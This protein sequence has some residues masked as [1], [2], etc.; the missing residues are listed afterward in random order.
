MSQM[1][2]ASK[3]AGIVDTDASNIE[4]AYQMKT[5]LQHIMDLPDTYIGSVQSEK[6][7]RWIK[8]SDARFIHSD[9]EFPPGLMHI[10][11][12]ILVNAYD[13]RNRVMQKLASGIKGLKPVSTI[14]VNVD[15]N[16]G[17][18]AIEN[19]G[20]GI[21][22]AMHQGAQVYVPE[23]I[24]GKLLTSGNYKT[25]EKRIVGG[26]NGYGAK[27]TNI[28]SKSFRVE[29]VDRKRKLYFCQDYFNNMSERTE[30][31]IKEN[32]KGD[33]FTRITFTPDYARFG[34]GMTKS[35]MALIEKRAYDMVACSSGQVKV[36]F[37]DIEV[38]ATCF[39]DYISMYI[40]ADAERSVCKVN[41][42]WEVAV[43]L[44]NSHGFEQVSFVNG[45]NTDRGGRHVDYVVKQITEA[46][47]EQIKKKKKVDVREDVIKS[48]IFV[49]VNSIIENPAF[50]SQTKNTL[51]TPKSKF[52][53]ECEVPEKFIDTILAAGLMDRA[54]ALSE[55]RDK[56]LL[57]KTDGKKVKRVL[58][59][60][61]LDDARYA[62]TKRSSECTLILTEGDS[63]KATAV[64]GISIFP[65]GRDYYG[66]F[67]LRGKPLNTRDRAEKD[68]AANVEITNI[69]KILGLQ[70]GKEYK[71]TSELR[72]GSIMLMTDADLDG[73][74]IKGL[75]INFFSHW[76]SLMRL[77]GFIT[78]LL[79]PILKASKGKK[80]VN[81]YSKPEFEEWVEARGGAKGWDVKYY[82]GLGTST[83][84]E[85]K[86]YF[87]EFKR[88]IYHW[89]D[90]SAETVD[91]AFNGDRADD[92][93]VWLTAYN[94]NA[95]L[96][97]AQTR[98]SFTDFINHDLIHFSNADNIRSIPSLCDGLKPSQRKVIYCCM[99][100]NLRKEIKVAQLAGY[101]SEH[102]AYH[103]GEVSLQGT[104]VNMA[105]NY[106]GANNINL[107]VP[108]GQFGTRL[109]G[110]KDVAAARYIFT[111]LPKLT[112]TLFNG[113]D[114]PL[115]SMVEDEGQQVEPLFY[116]PIIPLVLINGTEGI[117]TGW[118]SG[119][120]QFNPSDVVD[121]LRLMMAGQEPREMT[122]WYRGF[123]GFIKKI[124]PNQWLTR[125]IYKLEGTDTVVI[126]ELPVGVWTQSVKDILVSLTNTPTSQTQ[127]TNKKTTTPSKKS[128]TRRT[129]ASNAVVEL[130]KG[131]PIVKDYIEGHTESTVFFK[132][133]FDTDVLTQLLVEDPKTGINELEKLLCLTS[134]ISCNKM[135]TLYDE[136]GRL[137]TFKDPLEI[138]SHYYRLRLKYYEARKAHMIPQIEQELLYRSTRVRFIMDVISKV[139]RVNNRPKADIVRQLEEHDYPKMFEKHLMQLDTMTDVQREAGNY[140]YL[141][142]MP[143]YS[144]TRERIEELKAEQDELAKKLEDLKGKTIQMLWAEDLKEYE[145]EY[146][147]FM[148][149]F[150]EGSGLDPIE[151]RPVEKKRRI[152]NVKKTATEANVKIDD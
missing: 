26:R 117:G 101:I 48:N 50:D 130:T 79:T 133:K 16:S 89:D 150:Y 111:Y 58:D 47:C 113:H 98:V 86:E 8:G 80:V 107:L 33:A 143:I 90:T 148:K 66:I 94:A 41:E 27:L 51:T 78:T 129:K 3:K 83:S 144:L 20:E 93:K 134:K 22:I 110:G 25:G 23:L 60:P 141:V 124:G 142:G 119:V 149:E 77:D 131:D 1:K 122:P 6:A 31:L 76:E 35:L 65:D 147:S 145:V 105:Q 13:N 38:G 4:E 64:A 68:I 40:G 102:G 91:K 32:Y 71:N 92:R 139:I 125:G 72:Y 126:T 11:E 39:D 56:Q 12:E 84:A 70:E 146:A 104:I 69:K 74:H 10:I 115:Y 106:C 37:N 88:V 34:S 85:A 118:A 136:K 30:P 96:D 57:V 135:L 7:T 151:F 121:N 103:H 97:L 116:L 45:I 24:F 52:G 15:V 112:W 99:K 19:D 29:T 132:V 73:S 108:Q 9:F 140:D 138:L 42:R 59:I 67:P 137:R 123:R 63:A 18:I 54:I 21:D 81:F 36:W 62:G 43:A 2:T 75:I 44:S 127:S 82:K 95:V 120:P 55:F 109:Q 46:A 128:P 49:F 14:K 100:R 28:F 114:D 61:K 87:R 5:H 17:E 152:V 53:S